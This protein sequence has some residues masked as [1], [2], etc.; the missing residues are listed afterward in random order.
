MSIDVFNEPLQYLKG[1]GPRKGEVLEKAGVRTY[2]D[3]LHYFPRRYLDRSSVTPIA[4]IKPQVGSMT[5]VGS[6]VSTG[7]VPGGRRTRFEVV[8][9]DESGGRLKG[10]WFHRT[11]WIAKVFAKGDRVAFHGKPQ[12]FGRQFSI[13]HP[14]FDKLDEEGASL[15]TGRIIALY[16]G[17]AAFDK[18]GMTSRSF[19]KAVHGLFK[20]EGLRIPEVLPAW[21]VEKYK[22]MEG[23]VALRAAHFPKSS[24]ELAQGRER[25]KFEELF[26]IQLM[27]GMTRQGKQKV[28]GPVL[29]AKG[30]YM[31]RFLDDVLPFEL[32]GAQKNALEDIKK[33]TAKGI[34]MNRLVQGDVGSGK[35]VVAVAAMMHALDNGYQSAFMA[36]TEILAE[37]HYANLVKYLE[38]LGVEVRLLIGGQRKALREE[39]LEDIRE[40]RGHVVVGTHAVIQDKVAFKQLGMAIVDEQHRFG[41]LQRAEMLSKGD[42]PH[43]VLMTAT[44]IPRSLAMT[45]YGDLD[46]TVMDELPAGRKPIETMLRSDKRRGEVYAFI[47]EQLREG[48]QA[49]VVYPLV[50]ESEK[51]DLKDAESGYE[52]LVEEFRPYKVDLIHG[53]MF[54][55][56]KEEAMDRFKSG[57]TD[58]L[59]ATTV[60]EVG[61]DVPNATVMVIEHAE[62]FGLSQLHQLRGR[63]GRGGNQS[64]C[65]LMADYKRTAEAEERLNTMVA[66]TDGFQISEVDLKLRGAGDFFGTKQSG[67]PDLKIADI[68]V[69]VEILTS[70][71]DAAR[72]LLDKDPQL[73]DP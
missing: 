68:T 22:L 60:I 58:I 21:L 63:V 7:H 45:L 31:N 3:L 67:L 43:M 53:R 38:P 71:R 16:P 11:G 19:R 23:R 55:Y 36:P 46:V 61:V 29:E 18:V 44:P 73:Q 20:T 59:V 12:Q 37:Q 26:F 2:R 65:V 27:L 51:L 50:E 69:D 24:V 70:A 42:S 32:T 25:L 48:R 6:V 33:D 5:V 39:I 8:L 15:D 40:G 56:E 57:E 28:A 72:E 52:K 14:D 4:S 10:V 66:T 30:T 54:A 13:T 1:I 9:Q 41:V 47:K 35:T 64:Y 62:R 49:Y 17:G 34:Q